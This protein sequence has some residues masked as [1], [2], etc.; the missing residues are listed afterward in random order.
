MIVRFFKSIIERKRQKM[1]LRKKRK[2]E[3]ESIAE[4]IL[5]KNNLM[6]PRF[7]LIKYLKE[8]EKY[9]IALQNMPR[10]TTGFILVNDENNI[11]KDTASKLIAINSDLQYDPKFLQ[12]SRFII[13]HE[14]AHAILHKRDGIVLAHRSKSMRKTK[15]ER[16]ADLFA[17]SL[18]MPKKLVDQLLCR[19]SFNQLNTE[20]KINYM[21]AIFNVTPKKAQER[22]K[23][24]QQ[25]ARL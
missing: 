2:K 8:N 19:S 5:I 21:A 9:E 1:I 18:L 16:E 15:K 22:L 24:L 11:F 13:A 10:G 25:Y 20:N 7:D 3:I 23:D 4:N 12:K 14:F 17:R 6:Y